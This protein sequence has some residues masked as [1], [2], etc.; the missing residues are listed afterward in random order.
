MK[1]P[2]LFGKK[3]DEEEEDDFDPEDFEGEDEAADEPPEENPHADIDE[4]MEVGGGSPEG[5]HG[6]DDDDNDDE[7]EA[8]DAGAKKKA[9]LF[10]A[11]GGAVVLLSALG[12]VGWWYFSGDSVPPKAAAVRPGQPAKQEDGSIAMAM[13][14]KAGSLNSRAGGGLSLNQMAGGAVAP[15]QPVPGQP[16]PAQ[17]SEAPAAAAPSSAADAEAPLAQPAALNEAPTSLNSLNSLNAST[18]PGGG[19]VVPAVGNTLL[20]TIPDHAGSADQSQ[21]LSRAPVRALLEE[22]EGLKGQLPKIGANG[23]LP[24]QSYARPSDPGIT[25]PRIAIMIENIGLSRSASMA[26]INKLPPEISLILSPYGSDLNDWMF[27][28]RLAGHEVFVSLPMESENF[29]MEDPGPLGLDT[30]IQAAENEKRFDLVLSSVGGYVGVVT[31]M[32]SR[33][34]K[35]EGQMRKVLQPLKTR[36]LMFVIGGEK[37]RT[38]APSIA[39]ELALPRAES[40]VYIDEEPRIQPIRESLDR[41][42]SIAKDKGFAIATARPFPVTIKTILDWEKT[43]KDKDVK[44]VPVSALAQGA[45]GN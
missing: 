12:G 32:G 19:V 40:E 17:P 16:M 22:K 37:K 21:A 14:P 34:M 29:P 11:V 38:D 28:S 4:D 24:W 5:G 33:F 36:G 39:A 31:M 41:L 18:S 2:K 45:G 23:A 1:F 9:I 42:E 43:L 6:D 10:A 44:L 30:R 26:A 13:P 20:A 35:A 25:G 27:R 3:K 8:A 7:D 15:E